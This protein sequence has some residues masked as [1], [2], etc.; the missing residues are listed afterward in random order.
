MLEFLFGRY[1]PWTMDTY[2]LCHIIYNYEL[3]LL[4]ISI[5][6]PSFLGKGLGNSL[7]EW[8]PCYLI[9]SGLYL[10]VLESEVSQTYQRCSRY[11]AQFLFES[12]AYESFAVYHWIPFVV[13]EPI[14]FCGFWLVVTFGE[15]CSMAGRQVIEVSPTSVGGSCYAIAVSSRGVDIQKVNRLGCITFNAL[16]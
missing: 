13:L 4:F 2:H 14:L 15:C 5:F 6:F 3:W 12:P 9:L 1:F 7:A 8:Q 10:Y 11:V 16:Q